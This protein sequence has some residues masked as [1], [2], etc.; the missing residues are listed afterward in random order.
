MIVSIFLPFSLPSANMGKVKP[1]GIS[2]IHTI[3]EDFPP[4]LLK[5]MVDLLAWGGK[6]HLG[7]APG[8]YL[9]ADF[10]DSTRGVHKS[11]RFDGFSSESQHFTQTGGKNEEV[12]YRHECIDGLSKEIE[13]LENKSSGRRERNL[14]E[15]EEPG[16]SDVDDDDEEEEEEERTKTKRLSKK[17]R[18]SS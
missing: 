11:V 3:G 5:E 7:L 9:L 10:Y 16:I 13:R 8:L 1:R 15:D 18:A 17:R 4:E 14:H 6:D 12:D 2:A